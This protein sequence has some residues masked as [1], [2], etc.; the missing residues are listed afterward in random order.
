MA[1]VG[2]RGGYERL[3]LTLG[4]SASE[5]PHMMKRPSK[6]PTPPLDATGPGQA[7]HRWHH[8]CTPYGYV[9]LQ[10][11]LPHYVKV[12]TRQAETTKASSTHKERRKERCITTYDAP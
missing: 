5:N 9:Y 12:E 11:V 2:T 7:R 1:G 8:I 6:T 3:P 4:Q 10:T